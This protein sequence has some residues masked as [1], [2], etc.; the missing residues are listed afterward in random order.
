MNAK[1]YSLYWLLLLLTINTYYKTPS[2]LPLQ[3]SGFLYFQ[4]SLLCSILLLLK[5]IPTPCSTLPSSVTLICFVSWVI[6]TV[7]YLQ[8]SCNPDFLSV[9]I[10]NSYFSFVYRVIHTC[11]PQCCLVRTSSAKKSSNHP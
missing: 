1:V 6:H 2:G 10:T 3:G 9:Q 5:I 8:H 4:F 7:C 11:L